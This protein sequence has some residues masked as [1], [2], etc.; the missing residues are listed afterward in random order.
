MQGVGAWQPVVL[1]YLIKNFCSVENLG[2]D[3]LYEPV[4]VSEN[5][6]A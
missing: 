3:K 5:N 6:L 1:I 4:K 2:P